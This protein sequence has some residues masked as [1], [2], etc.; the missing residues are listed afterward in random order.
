MVFGV[1]L[2]RWWPVFH[3]LVIAA[4]FGCFSHHKIVV[5]DGLETQLRI[6]IQNWIVAAEIMWWE[7]GTAALYVAV[8]V[9]TK[10]IFKCAICNFFYTGLKLSSD[11]VSW[12]TYTCGSDCHD[13]KHTSYIQFA[14][15]SYC[16]K[17][18]E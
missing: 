2:L 1:I 18:I 15:F 17:I 6:P 11:S 16:F 3:Q 4:V 5:C 13:E 12:D 9:M 8:I 7:N 10:H 14:I